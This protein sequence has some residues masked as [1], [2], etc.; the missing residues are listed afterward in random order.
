M[1]I[2]EAKYVSDLK[3]DS[4]SILATIDGVKMTVPQDPDNRHYQEI[5]KQVADKK[6]TIKEAE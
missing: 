2:K 5:Q 1:D 4:P 3:S 6:L